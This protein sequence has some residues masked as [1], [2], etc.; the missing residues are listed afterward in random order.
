MKMTFGSLFAGIGGFDLGLERAGM[1]CLWQCER[2]KFCNKVLAKHW[3]EVTR[4]DDI[5]TLDVSAL[6]PVDLICGGFPC[7]PFSVS[8][9]RK[10]A[11]DDRF[12]WP[13]MLKVIETVR[14]TWVLGE[15]VPGLV[16]M[17]IE[18]MLFDLEN[19]GY[20]VRAFVV[21]ACAVG[22]EHRRDRVWIV[23]HSEQGVCSSDRISHIDTMEK[24]GSR[25]S[26]DQNMPYL[27]SKWDGLNTDRR[28]LRDDARFS[29]N[30]DRIG[31]VGNSVNV[32]LVTA[33]GRMIIEA[34]QFRGMT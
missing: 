16:S 7:Q 3:P 29:E 23:A 11:E 6:A 19:I 30:V 13:A 10:G 14:P 24:L 8:G 9:K 1:K 34:H 25:W 22:A 33:I 27:G 32:N 28:T 21:P 18:N 26:A 4:Y 17:G 12:L 31:A 15:N 2:D 20:G 5:T